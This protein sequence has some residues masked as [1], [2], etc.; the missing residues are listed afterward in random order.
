MPIA[1]VVQGRAS[2]ICGKCRDCHAHDPFPCPKN[3]AHESCPG[4]DPVRG[5]DFCFDCVFSCCGSYHH[6][7][8]ASLDLYLCLCHVDDHPCEDYIVS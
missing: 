8:L 6:H 7:I 3:P 5:L 4:P 2:L 1:M